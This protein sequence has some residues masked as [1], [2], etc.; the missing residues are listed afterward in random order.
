MWKMLQDPQKNI[1]YIARVLAYEAK[2]QGVSVNTTSIEARKNIFAAY[3][4][5]NY[6][7]SNQGRHYASRTHNYYVEF[8]KIRSLGIW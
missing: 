7:S 8:E 5:G 6:Y 4:T 2:Q 1:E 3:N